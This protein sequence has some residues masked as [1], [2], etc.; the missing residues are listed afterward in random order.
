MASR[1]A[2]T[3]VE[4]VFVLI[5]VGV[6]AAFATP[7]FMTSIEQTKASTAQG[8][9]L[10][11]AAAEEKYNEDYSSYCTQTTGNVIPCA[12]TAVEINTNLKLSV[13]VAGDPFTYNCTSGAPYTC[14]AQDGATVT[15]TLTPGA[16]PPVTCTA[17]GNNCPYH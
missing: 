11:I 17:G 14:T 6:L 7:V 16:Q 13:G 8:N 5:I 3:I 4:I 1:K 15:L 10:A 9:L 2:F 12:G